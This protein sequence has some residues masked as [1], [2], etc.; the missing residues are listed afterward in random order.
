MKDN[1]YL[2]TTSNGKSTFIK[3]AL[4]EDYLHLK[5]IFKSFLWLSSKTENVFRPQYCS[6]LLFLIFKTLWEIFHAS[7]LNRL[8]YS[9]LNVDYLQ[10]YI[11]L[12]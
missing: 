3:L 6:T 10:L 9:G 7:E 12:L 5:D 11:H 1:F 2:T 8:Y 4:M